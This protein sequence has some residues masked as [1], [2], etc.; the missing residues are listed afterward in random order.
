MPRKTSVLEAENNPFAKR[1]SEIMDETGTTQEALAKSLEVR[2]Q[3]VALYKSGQSSPDAEKL[4]LIV[5]HFENIES[6]VT[7]DWLLGLTGDRSRTPSA[8]D[9]LGL[10]AAA[11]AELRRIKSKPAYRHTI[12]AILEGGELLRYL[13]NYLW[14]FMLYDHFSSSAL[15]YVPIE[16]KS[17]FD[18]TKAVMFAALI[19]YLPEYREQLREKC[20]TVD[21]ETVEDFY[22]SFLENNAD[23][24]ECNKII[25]SE[26]EPEH[27]EA[28]YGGFLDKQEENDFWD[29]YY[30]SR[31]EEYLEAAME[32]QLEIERAKLSAIERFLRYMNEKRKEAPPCPDEAHKETAPSGSDQTDAGKPDM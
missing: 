5:R 26:Y 25:D 18:A 29:D 11:M 6:P 7:A 21:I 28:E 3:T 23:I 17:R 24:K 22:L 31:D 30:N 1:L 13:S 19:E 14:S 15:K 27:H 2:R 4:A 12:N 9:E 32:K 20:K 10:T 16:R 8:I